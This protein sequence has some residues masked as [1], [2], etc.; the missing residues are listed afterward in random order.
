MVAAGGEAGR[1]RE[2]RFRGD[3][4]KRAWGGD[5]GTCGRGVGRGCEGSGGVGG[6]FGGGWWRLPEG[7]TCGV[8]DW[9]ASVTND[10]SVTGEG[11]RWAPL[12]DKLWL[13]FQ[14][15]AQ[16][17]IRSSGASSALSGRLSSRLFS[18]LRRRRI[19]LDSSRRSRL[20]CH[21]NPELRPRTCVTRSL[22]LAR[23]HI[24]GGGW[25]VRRRGASASL[26]CG[27]LNR[28][29]GMGKEG[30]GG[31]GG[32]DCAASS[33]SLPPDLRVDRE[34]LTTARGYNSEGKT[35]GP[36]RGEKGGEEGGEGL[37]WRLLLRGEVSDGDLHRLHRHRGAHRGHPH[38]RAAGAARGSG[39]RD[40]GHSREGEEVVATPAAEAKAQQ[41]SASAGPKSR[42]S[43]LRCSRSRA[44][45]AGEAEVMQLLSH[46]LPRATLSSPALAGRCEPLLSHRIELPRKRHINATSDEDSQISHA[47]MMDKISIAGTL[48]M[49]SIEYGHHP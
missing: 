41:E 24:F 43:I 2:R 45:G 32:L 47:S 10:R 4:V 16:V 25:P 26:P 13:S 22:R 19:A 48:V 29:R 8:P 17:E 35:K 44:V 11:R 12:K 18:L 31:G 49:S 15:K 42:R 39:W 23:E 46:R 3:D 20:R 5:V 33:S 40:G 36:R 28:H 6:G 7:Q 37:P 14:A 30:R 27:I 9:L 21:L 1:G 38:P 34:S